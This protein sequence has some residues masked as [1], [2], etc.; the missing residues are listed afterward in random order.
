MHAKSIFCRIR[1]FVTPWTV[2]H[3]APLSMGLCRQEC[4]SGLPCPPPGEIPNPGTKPRSLLSPE[5]GGGFFTTTPP[6]NLQCTHNFYMHQDTKNS[7][8]SLFAIFTLLQFSGP[9]PTISLRLACSS[10]CLFL[11]LLPV[12]F[13]LYHINHRQG[14]CQE[15]FLGVL[16]SPILSIQ[17]ILS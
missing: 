11:I 16:E 12:L 4:W 9:G 6:G 1:L 5:L 7:C 8:D 3:Q 14:Q 10:T 13:V 15:V 17:S 2:A